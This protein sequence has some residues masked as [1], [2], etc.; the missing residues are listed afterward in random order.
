MSTHGASRAPPPGP[1]FGGGAPLAGGAQSLCF[2]IRLQ[3]RDQDPTTYT[4]TFLESP[5]ILGPRGAFFSHHAQV[6]MLMFKIIK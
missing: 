2:P 3:P 6:H 5:S 1:L 4:F